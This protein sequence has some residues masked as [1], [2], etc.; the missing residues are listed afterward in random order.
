MILEELIF[1]VI[2]FILP[3][4]T[5]RSM[6]FLNVRIDVFR[7]KTTFKLND[8]MFFCLIRFLVFQRYNFTNN[9]F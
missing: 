3:Q 4:D 5:I 7:T 6:T 2:K 9:N 1:Q 8:L